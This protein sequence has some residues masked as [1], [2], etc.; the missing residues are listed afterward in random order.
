MCH[1]KGIHL[2][3]LFCKVSVNKQ[4]SHFYTFL[5]FLLRDILLKIVHQNLTNIVPRTVCDSS[6]RVLLHWKH[7]FSLHN[8]LLLSNK[9]HLCFGGWMEFTV[10][11]GMEKYYNHL[12]DI[13]HI[14]L[15]MKTRKNIAVFL[16]RKIIIRFYCVPI[17][18]Y[19]ASKWLTSK[20]LYPQ[21]LASQTVKK[22]NQTVFK[23]G[24]SRKILA[25]SFC[26]S[27]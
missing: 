23:A 19:L 22:D 3:L 26:K 5:I 10:S 14:H 9:A 11:P 4:I 15:R 25:K 1:S 16:K 7:L 27:Y 20:G 17:S 18:S 13:S 6:S 12:L 24:I 2:S 8:V 21:L